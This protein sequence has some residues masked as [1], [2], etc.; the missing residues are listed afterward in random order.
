MV[1]RVGKE[2]RDAVCVQEIKWDRCSEI[3]RERER[4]LVG[5]SCVI[6][7]A[8]FHGQPDRALRCAALQ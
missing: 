3:E 1:E 2:S 6:C 5:E 4:D 8:Q 7:V